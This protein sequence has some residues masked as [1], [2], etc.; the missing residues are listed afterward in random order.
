MD[1]VD[2]EHRVVEDGVTGR[3]KPSLDVVMTENRKYRLKVVGEA[4]IESEHGGVGR[5]RGAVKRSNKILYGY[6]MMEA[7][8]VGEL[9]PEC[10]KAQA[11]DTGVAGA[12][13]VTNIVVHDNRKW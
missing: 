9:L 3:E 8:H 1:L 5:Q 2:I 4:V 11:L 10:G 7:L 6:K 13:E 12:L